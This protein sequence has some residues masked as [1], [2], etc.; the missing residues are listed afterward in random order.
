[1]CQP[2]CWPLGHCG[3]P[4]VSEVAR[5]IFFTTSRR[6]MALFQGANHAAEVSAWSRATSPRFFRLGSISC[7]QNTTS[8]EFLDRPTCRALSALLHFLATGPN[9]QDF[10]MRAINTTA[11]Q[12]QDID[13]ER[14]GTRYAILSHTWD[15][16]EVLLT[17][18]GIS[19]R[20]ISSQPC[21]KGSQQ[22]HRELC[23]GQKRPVP[24]HLD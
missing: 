19:V 21:A 16:E 1:M 23:P 3:F 10:T 20:A 8:S 18:S 17:T 14:H 7:T 22:S 12:L 4:R 9:F 13:P 15:S 2:G 24:L 6:P 5:W 11:L